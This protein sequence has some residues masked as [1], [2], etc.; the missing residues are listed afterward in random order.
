MTRITNPTVASLGYSVNNRT[1]FIFCAAEQAFPQ[2]GLHPALPGVL[3][4]CPWLWQDF[5][6]H[7]NMEEHA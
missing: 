6:A 5:F 2:S 1:V 7:P 3:A 4:Y